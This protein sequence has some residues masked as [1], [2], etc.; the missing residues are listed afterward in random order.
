[1]E[2]YLHFVTSHPRYRSHFF[3]KAWSLNPEMF[4]SDDYNQVSSLSKLI[5]SGQNWKLQSTIEANEISFRFTYRLFIAFDRFTIHIFPG[6]FKLEKQWHKT[7][8]HSDEGSCFYS[9]LKVSFLFLRPSKRNP[10]A[11]GLF[12]IPRNL[13]NEVLLSVAGQSQE[14][15]SFF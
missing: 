2:K 3:M 10:P 8:H 1:M 9:V 15:T 4:F 11:D 7:L 5:Q 13:E 6:L 14:Q 12:T